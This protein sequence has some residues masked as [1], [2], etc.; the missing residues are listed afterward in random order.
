MSKSLFVTL[1][2]FLAPF[3]ILNIVKDKRN[4]L[5]ALSNRMCILN[6]NGG[7]KIWSMVKGV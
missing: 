4:Y 2:M 1:L 7:F 6:I 3:K 5:L